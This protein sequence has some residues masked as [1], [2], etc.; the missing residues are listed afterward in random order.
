M[1]GSWRVIHPT[2]RMVQIEVVWED[3][4]VEKKWW[5]VE[6]ERYGN[7]FTPGSELLMADACT[8]K[9]EL[10]LKENGECIKQ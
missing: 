3:G 2:H 5:V 7:L 10:V 1:T 9:P 4:T 8:G 6:S